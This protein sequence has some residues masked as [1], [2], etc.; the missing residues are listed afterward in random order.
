MNGLAAGSEAFHTFLSS[1]LDSICSQEI[2]RFLRAFHR[3]GA[4]RMDPPRSAFT[5][6]SSRSPSGR[7]TPGAR[8]RLVGWR[9]G[10]PGDPPRGDPAFYLCGLQTSSHGGLSIPPGIRAL[11]H[12]ILQSMTHWTRAA[13]VSRKFRATTNA[14]A[15]ARATQTNAVTTVCTACC[16]VMGIVSFSLFPHG[17]TPSLGW[18]VME[19][20]PL[21]K[22]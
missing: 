6:P 9:R 11:P 13:G 2:L 19:S 22:M 5:S 10:P 12:F 4:R 20:I 8:R 18:R 15:P 7:Q 14:V 3:G 17:G 16:V 1:D 21:G